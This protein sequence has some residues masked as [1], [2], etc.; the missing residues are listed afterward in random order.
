[1]QVQI[2]TIYEDDNILIVNKP[3]GMLS[4]EELIP[5]IGYP[6]CNRLDR[7]TSGII[8]AAKHKTAFREITNAETE[9]F[10]LATVIKKPIPTTAVATAYLKAGEK[11]VE[12][13]NSPADGYKKIITEYRLIAEKK[14]GL[15][16]LEVILH[17]GKKHQIRSHLAHLGF[18]I[19]GDWKYGNKAVNKKFGADFQHLTAYK[20]TFHFSQNSPLYYL[21]ERSFEVDNT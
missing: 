7:N 16:D 17:T 10:Y 20:I 4:Q 21:N 6:I 12:I 15:Y 5:A 1:M 13:K 14:G 11:F 2:P 8:I 9:K 18:P 3:A 19:L